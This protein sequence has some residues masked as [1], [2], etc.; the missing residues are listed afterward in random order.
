MKQFFDT[1]V[2]VAA[3]VG[4]HP[5]HEA[6]A[7]VFAK[8]GKSYSLCAAHSLAEVYA[9]L[10]RLP[11]KPPIAPEHAML[12]LQEVRQR[13]TCVTLNETDY[14]ATLKR[15]AEQHIIGGQIYD[16]LLMEC[17][18]KAKAAVIYTWNVKHFQQ[19]NP[20]LVDKIKTPA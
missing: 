20:I 6:S 16:A 8:A 14:Y 11:L 9:T 7:K 13:F 5:H 1:S 10:T 3:F 18:I 2:L 19:I 4:D 17:A 15:L 12:F